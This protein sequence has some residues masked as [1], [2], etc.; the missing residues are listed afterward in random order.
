MIERLAEKVI[1]ED[2]KQF[3]IVGI[4]GPRQVGKTTLARIIM[5]KLEQRTVYLDLELQ[6]DIVKLEY[7]EIYFEDHKDDCV[8]LDEI[9]TMPELF[10]IL[11]GMI[12]KYRRPGRFVIL[13]SASPSLIRKSSDSL[14]GRIS[15]IRL[16]PLNL[17]ELGNKWE[18]KKHWFFGGFPEPYLSKDDSFSRKWIRSFVQT[19]T[20]RDLPLLGLPSTPS[21]TR[22]F[23]TML[24]NYQGGI[25][26]ASNFAKSMGLSYP[27]LNR[28]LD[29]LEEAFLVTRLQPFSHNIKK[30]LVKSPKVYIR[31]SGIL[32]LLASI[33]DFEQLQGNVLIGNSWEGYVLEQIRQVLSP[34]I[35]FYFYRTHNGAECDLVLV[36]GFTP[37]SAIEIKYTVAPKMT[38]GYSIAIEDLGTRE[39]YI[40]TPYSETFSKTENV[41]VCSLVDYLTKYLPS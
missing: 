10:S 27:T 21:V 25:W 31:D 24:A 19:Y 12:D 20:D 35:D 16:S 9:Q 38:K 36:K 26:N 17:M 3:P 11:R 39:N 7:A 8:I 22:R 18:L 4:I 30:R 32:H 34:D 33:S 28:Y 41:K 2:I 13:G 15:Y 1:L 37:V 23:L 5:N 40:I 29:V 14:A 6:E